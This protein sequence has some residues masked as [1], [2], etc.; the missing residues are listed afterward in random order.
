MYYAVDVIFVEQPLGVAASQST[1]S[2]PRGA[3]D[4]REH[5]TGAELLPVERRHAG[6]LGQAPITGQ[7][8]LQ[9]IAHDILETKPP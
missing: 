9:R 4:E 5:A 1:Q 6:R 2:G 8:T 7:V 3:G